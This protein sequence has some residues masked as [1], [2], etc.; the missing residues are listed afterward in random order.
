MMKNICNFIHVKLIMISF[1]LL[2]TASCQEADLLIEKDIVGNS[3]ITNVTE[4]GLLL[5]DV[6]N[7]FKI[8]YKGKSYQSDFIF[9]D[10]NEIC[11][12]SDTIHA[13]CSNHMANNE[14][15]T[16][17]YPDGSIE[18]FDN[19]YDWENS[20]YYLSLI[21]NEKEV[22]Q[23]YDFAQMRK[24]ETIAFMKLFAGKRYTGIRRFYDFHIG[25]LSVYEPDLTIYEG[26][27][28]AISSFILDYYHP[29]FYDEGI[30]I[31][32]FFRRP[33]YEGPSLVVSVDA[34][35]K[36]LLE[37]SDISK[38]LAWAGVWDDIIQSYRAKLF[39]FG[40]VSPFNEVTTK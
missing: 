33:N 15:I 37:V 30:L 9:V 4:S 22:L 36:S 11:L 31:V 1:L 39:P 23:K 14:G 12:L 35:N 5:K 7:V 13:I 8:T 34:P 18:F 16:A 19:S 21:R 17:V 6:S 10:K 24:S 25:R 3:S 20:D 28:M 38:S 32:E 27:D 40:N 2:T 29:P 26:F